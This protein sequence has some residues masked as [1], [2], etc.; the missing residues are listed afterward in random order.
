MRM[1]N[2]LTVL[3]FRLLAKVPK[4]LAVSVE[5]V[6]I[7]YIR[8]VYVSKIDKIKPNMLFIATSIQ[9][10]MESLRLMMSYTFSC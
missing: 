9:F 3:S 10:C 7:V 8:N 4:V 5:L 2:L 1:L 6:D